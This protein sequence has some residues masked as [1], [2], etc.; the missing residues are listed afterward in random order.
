M[1][2]F[3]TPLFATKKWSCL[4]IVFLFCKILVAQNYWSTTQNCLDITCNNYTLNASEFYQNLK[5][6]KKG[7]HLSLTL[8]NPEVPQSFIKFKVQKTK[9]FSK[10]LENKFNTIKT[11]KGTQNGKKGYKLRFSMSQNKLPVFYFTGFSNKKKWKLTPKKNNSYHFI[12]ETL[13][14]NRL[15]TNNQCFVKETTTISPSTPLENRAAKNSNTN[16]TGE[17]ITLRTAILA[18]GEYSEYFITK[19]NVENSIESIQKEIVLHAIA[20]SINNIN[21]V[22]EKDLGVHLELISNNDE[23][24]FL[25]S[26]TDPFHN[27]STIE[28]IYF[29]GNTQIYDLIGDTNFDIGHVFDKGFAGLARVG[30]ICSNGKAEGVSGAPIPEGT[31]FDFTVLAHELGHQLG[32]THTQN[33]NCARSESGSAVE[34]GSGSTIMGYAGACDANA[35]IQSL[36]DEY[37]HYISMQQIQ[38]HLSQVT[39]N[40]TKETLINQ[41]PEITPLESYIIPAS[42][43]FKLT[44]EATDP[45]GDTL[46][47]NWEQLDSDETTI[48]LVS[49]A[50]YG[51]LFRSY[52][53]STSPERIF[54]PDEDNLWEVLP[55][56]S[57]NLHFGLSIRD[58]QPSN[59][60]TEE[61]EISVINTGEVF[62][63][64]NLENYNYVQ[65]LPNTIEWNVANTADNTFINTSKVKIEISYDNGLSYTEVLSTE[66]DNDGIEEVHFPS[67][68]TSTEARIKISAIDNIFF[69]ESPAITINNF[70]SSNI[71]DLILPFKNPIQGNLSIETQN[72]PNNTEITFTIYQLNGKK[73]NQQTITGVNKTLNLETLA[74]GLYLCKIQ[75]GEIQ[76]VKKIVIL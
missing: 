45:E 21:Q 62:E 41:A 44:A 54:N 39:C 9:V 70:E 52:P 42:C 55:S 65:G 3:F 51:P 11:F 76:K 50:E 71:D 20:T 56:V 49:S 5:D 13:H 72:I 75:I 46:Y 63:I 7:S 37:F 74:S 59:V 67:N 73:L 60:V 6:L 68:K 31:G 2:F 26:D 36:S 19:N 22:F 14:T 16:Q 27:N 43:A 53:P 30:A 47:Y 69:T 35:E 4:C 12:E 25:D 48:P 38:D 18:K 33:Y 34:P 32:A 40:L 64:I 23:L 28:N 17:L 29:E 1:R 61:M 66:T 24:I 57:R 58:G 15:L 8:P 10:E